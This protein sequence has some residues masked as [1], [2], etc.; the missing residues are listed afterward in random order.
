MRQRTLNDYGFDKDAAPLKRAD[1]Q[2]IAAE[3]DVG[4]SIETL[5]PRHDE[6][7][8]GNGYAGHAGAKAPAHRTRL[9]PT[10]N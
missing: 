8:L 9:R 3:A 2:E 4:L 7:T 10:L 5:E 1:C 6:R